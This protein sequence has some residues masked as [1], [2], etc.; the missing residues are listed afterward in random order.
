MN[1]NRSSNSGSAGTSRRGSSASTAIYNNYGTVSSSN[2]INIVQVQQQ[3]E[4]II[5]PS[6]LGR[7]HWPVTAGGSLLTTT[8]TTATDESRIPIT[9]TIEEYAVENYQ[10]KQTIDALSNRLAAVE[11]ENR[12]LKSS[13]LTLRKHLQPPSK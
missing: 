10:L 3:T 6:P 8:T 4:R 7:Q 1:T 9:K 11:D 12:L 13:L 2:N 5:R